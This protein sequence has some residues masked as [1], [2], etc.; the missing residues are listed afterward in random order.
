METQETYRQRRQAVADQITTHPETF[1]M[2]SFV[3][4]GFGPDPLC[5]TTCCIA[6]WAMV[7]RQDMELRV[8]EHN[9][10]D[11]HFVWTSSGRPVGLVEDFAA[12]WLGIPDSDANYLFYGH[13]SPFEDED[14]V[15]LHGI[16]PEQAVEALMAAPYVEVASDVSG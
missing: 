16:T 2:A 9:V 6:G 15:F 5:G 13:F 10:H 11:V 1:N 4:A 3:S 14:E 12:E 7:H 8:V